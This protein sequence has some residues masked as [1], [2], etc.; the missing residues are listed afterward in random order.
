MKYLWLFAF[1]FFLSCGESEIDRISRLKLSASVRRLNLVFQDLK[2]N[3]QAEESLNLLAIR[4][5]YAKYTD[6]LREIRQ[7]VASEIL[8]ENYRL[9]CIKLDSLISLSIVYINHR[10]E[11]VLGMHT[12]AGHITE[13][14]RNYKTALD[15]QKSRYNRVR[16]K[17]YIKKARESSAAYTQ[18]RLEYTEMVGSLI[19]S[20][21]KIQAS[22]ISWNSL[23]SEYVLTDTLN[24]HTTL[25][26]TPN[27]FFT[28]LEKFRSF[29]LPVDASSQ[30]SGLN[31]NSQDA[32]MQPDIK[33]FSSVLL[34]Q[35]KNNPS[36]VSKALKNKLVLIENARVSAIWGR[37]NIVFS[38][39]DNYKIRAYFPSGVLVTIG[40]EID[41]VGRYDKHTKY[42]LMFTDCKMVQ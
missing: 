9:H 4:D 30:E 40:D 5:F 32:F 7:E 29:H 42:L 23:T 37:D 13:F 18:S 6:Q 26:D 31:D 19:E 11:A 10:Q 12:V 28:V 39:G 17:E 3:K 41:F 2:D 16:S 20:A 21:N 14:E 25:V 8:S 22:A 15:Y 34:L 35:F 36:T 38:T 33:F 1:L 24:F 27:I